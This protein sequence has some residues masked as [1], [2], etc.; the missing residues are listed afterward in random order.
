MKT[1]TACLAAAVLALPLVASAGTIPAGTKSGGKAAVTG[2]TSA[3]GGAVS[4]TV[5]T[6][7]GTT[8]VTKSAGS[9]ATVTR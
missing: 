5:T 1:L 3:G 2:S 4:T 6:P 9:K 7:G 8:T